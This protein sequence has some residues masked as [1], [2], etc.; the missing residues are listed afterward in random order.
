[1]VHFALRRVPKQRLEALLACSRRS[2][3]YDAD[4]SSALG[5]LGASRREI[6]QQLLAESLLLSLLGGA[7][8]AGLSVLILKGL[9]HLVPAGSP[10]VGEASIDGTVLAFTFGISLLTGVLFGLFPARQLS[11]LDTALAL[12][13]GTRTSTAGRKQHRLQLGA[14][15]C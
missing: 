9:L 13:D 1:M 15:D 10:R 14:G 2:G 3:S 7:V 5:E 6:V 11:R 8:G 4:W 12:R